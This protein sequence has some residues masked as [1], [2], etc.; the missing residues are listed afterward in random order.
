[1]DDRVRRRA[2]VDDDFLVAMARRVANANIFDIVF[3]D[4]NNYEISQLINRLSVL[5]CY[6]IVSLYYLFRITMSEMMVYRKNIIV[7]L[8]CASFFA[9]DDAKS[10]EKIR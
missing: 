6:L 4:C 9:D 8:S 10:F 5:F 7:K 2:C 1:M 3:L